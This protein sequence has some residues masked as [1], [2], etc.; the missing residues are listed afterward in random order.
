VNLPLILKFIAG[1]VALAL[2]AWLAYLKMTPLDP[3]IDLLKMGL[4]GLVVHM[5]QDPG[6]PAVGQLVSATSTAPPTN[7]QSGHASPALLGIAAF[8]MVAICLGACTTPPTSTQANQIRMAC[9]ADAGIRP[10]VD[11]LLA[12]PGLAK[13]EEVAA[14]VAARAVIDPIC[15][16]PSAPFAGG[17]PYVAI[18]QASGTL[19]G[20]L[21]QL[22]TRKAQAK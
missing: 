20:V 10:S 11:I 19:A 14:V 1:L 21:V 4:G 9:A 18:S 5:L 3:L 15:K 17:D 22:E 16:D 2:W 8:L 6:M 13:P 12:I 7:V